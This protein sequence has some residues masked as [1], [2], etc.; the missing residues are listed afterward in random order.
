MDLYKM[1][2]QKKLNIKHKTKVTTTATTKKYIK[3]LFLLQLQIAMNLFLD[4]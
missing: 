2:K 3:T 1:N 4:L